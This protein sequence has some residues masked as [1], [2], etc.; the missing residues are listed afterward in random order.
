MD[1]GSLLVQM[2]PILIV[3]ALLRWSKGLRYWMLRP[4]IR[5]F[6]GKG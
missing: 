3:C 4:L 6:Q 2:T 5:F 1:F